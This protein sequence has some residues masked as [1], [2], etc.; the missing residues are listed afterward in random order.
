[1][2]LRNDQTVLQKYIEKS[3]VDLPSLPSIVMQVLTATEKDTVTTTEIESLI[4][5]DV[6][7]TA[8]LLKVVNSAYFGAPRQVSSVGQAISILG[9]QQI[10]NLVLSVGVLNALSSPSPRVIEIQRKFWEHA[11]G[12]ATCAQLLAKTKK[13]Q[14]KDQE[15]V[16]IGALLQDVGRLFLLT[17]FNQPYMQVLSESEKHKEPVL[18]TEQRILT[19]THPE[20]G[21]ILATQWN[22]P[23]SLTN[24]IQ[25]HESPEL[26]QGEPGPIYCVHVAGRISINL[27]EGNE[28][29][30]MWPWSEQAQEWF[31]FDQ[32]D[33]EE[34]SKATKGFVEQA[35]T[36][37]GVL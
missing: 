37:L 28:R 18:V 5:T 26:Y 11:F 13:L 8:K 34:L 31:N 25:F 7:L 6:G 21:G 36:L 3:M 24:L 22:F 23:E 32:E 19:T 16:F 4:S 30:S 20:L 2:A 1:M 17:L 9:M 33:L 14:A 12:A 10:R 29:E 15:L 27:W 35:R